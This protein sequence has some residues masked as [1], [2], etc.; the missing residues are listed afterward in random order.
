MDQTT[1]IGMLIMAIATLLGITSIVVTI[2]IKPIINLN[3]SITK[4]NDNI[5]HL[6]GQNKT[7][8]TRVA[9]HGEQID[10]NTQLLIKHDKDIEFL[11]EV[12]LK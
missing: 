7:L 1:F 5:D 9:K 6:T 11:K 3:K 4:L 8:E 12:K 10:K 2:V